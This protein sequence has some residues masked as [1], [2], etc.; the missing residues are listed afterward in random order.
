MARLSGISP[1]LNDAG[2][3]R[4]RRSEGAHPDVPEAVGDRVLMVL[5]AEGGF[6][7]EGAVPVRRFFVEGG[8]EELRVVLHDDAVDDDGDDQS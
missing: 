1:A 2:V 3:F 4:R 7:G 6:F 8:A 5:E